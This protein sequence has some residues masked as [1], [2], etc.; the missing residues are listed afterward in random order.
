MTGIAAKDGSVIEGKSVVI[1]NVEYA[2]AAF[3]KKPEYEGAQID[4]N[5]VTVENAVQELL[6]EL[7]SSIMLDGSL[8]EGIEKLDIDALYARFE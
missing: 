4:L 3:R 6:V 8:V 5:K 1:N 7:K 2:F